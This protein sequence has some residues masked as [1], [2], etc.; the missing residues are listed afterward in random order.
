VGESTA[1][2]FKPRREENDLQPEDTGT[3]LIRRDITGEVHPEAEPEGESE[4][5]RIHI[6]QEGDTLED[7]SRRYYGD[8]GHTGPIL[9]ANRDQIDDDGGLRPGAALR[10]PP[11]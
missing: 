2:N 5:V 6:V 11:A 1:K 4:G 7:L 3:P 9:D 10:I 8:P